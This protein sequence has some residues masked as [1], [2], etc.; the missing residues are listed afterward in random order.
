M[1]AKHREAAEST[2][3]KNK[4][5]E[6]EIIDALQREH[7]KHDAVVK[8]MYRLRSLRLQR[9]EAKPK[10]ALIG[11]P[12]S[13]TETARPHMRSRAVHKEVFQC[14]CTFPAMERRATATARDL[15]ICRVWFNF[16][17]DQLVLSPTVRA[18]KRH[19]F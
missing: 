18:L 2:F 15:A 19:G 5:R 10:A 12:P 11:Q 17:A 16:N 9:E 7:A 14:H 13:L 8:N 3:D 6:A 4:R 1:S